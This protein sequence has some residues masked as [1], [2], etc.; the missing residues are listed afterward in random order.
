MS[1]RH[2]TQSLGPLTPCPRP[3]RTG[4]LNTRQCTRRS[5]SSRMTNLRHLEL[6]G[7]IVSGLALLRFVP[8]SRPVRS[9]RPRD[10]LRMFNRY[11]TRGECACVCECFKENT[12]VD[13]HCSTRTFP[14][15]QPLWERNTELKRIAK[16]ISREKN[17]SLSMILHIK[18]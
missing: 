4:P 1:P 9:S 5:P 13:L 12:K 2:T 3:Q 6:E 14:A 10:H 17:I 16:Q 7:D 18:C 8:D 11:C 15:G